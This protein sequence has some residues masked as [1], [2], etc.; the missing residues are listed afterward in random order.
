MRRIIQARPIAPA[1]IGA[2]SACPTASAA[3]AAKIHARINASI[4]TAVS[5]S[6]RGE[7]G[8]SFLRCK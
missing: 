4:K 3:T 8:E 6:R 1:S 2:A 5:Q 7:S